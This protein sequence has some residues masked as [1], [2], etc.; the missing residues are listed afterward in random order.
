MGANLHDAQKQYALA[1]SLRRTM[2]THTQAP[3]LVVQI[4]VLFPFTANAER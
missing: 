2:H 1:I 3:S 4:V